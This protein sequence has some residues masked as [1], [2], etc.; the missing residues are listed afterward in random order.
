MIA[1]K[2]DKIRSGWQLLLEL[3]QIIDDRH[4]KNAIG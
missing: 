4:N 1:Q 3:E 2:S